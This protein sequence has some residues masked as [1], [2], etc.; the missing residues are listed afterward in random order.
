MSKK[1]VREIN[2]PSRPSAGATRAKPENSEDTRRKNNRPDSN[3][4]TEFDA[5]E[6]PNAAK[7]ARDK[8]IKNS[9]G[10][11][12]TQRTPSNLPSCGE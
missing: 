10:I 3:V 5:K 11:N 4:Q 7:I 8:Q 9:A 6:V 12:D 2:V 1:Q